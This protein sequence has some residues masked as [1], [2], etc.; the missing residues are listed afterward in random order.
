LGTELR[1]DAERDEIFRVRLEQTE[2]GVVARP[3]PAKSGLVT[4]MTRA[5]GMVYLPAGHAKLQAGDPVDVQLL[6]ERLGGNW[7]GRVR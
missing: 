5:H 3:L 1:P 7:Q 4:V 6:V 2:A